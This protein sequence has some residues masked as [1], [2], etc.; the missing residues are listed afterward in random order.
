MTDYAAQSDVSP[1]RSG[2]GWI[3]ATGLVLV[4]GG[5]LSMFHPFATSLATALVLGCAMIAG[6]AFAVAAG[7]AVRGGGQSWLYILLGLASVLLGIVVLLYPFVAA[8]SLVWTT[9]AWLIAAGL[10]QIAAGVRRRGRLWLVLL[11]ALDV[12]LG[13]LLLIM[14]PIS[15]IFFL[16]VA[17][18]LTFALHGAAMLALA[19][20]MRRT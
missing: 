14:D 12:L 20:R 4:V 10:L 8:V 3:A 7:T 15:A 11:G 5:L 6:G 13:G 2:R 9:G 18:G 19:L 1:S 16:A 17:V